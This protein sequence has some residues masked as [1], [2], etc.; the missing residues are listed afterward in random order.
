MNSSSYKEEK[1]CMV[2][3]KAFGTQRN[4]LQILE[5]NLWAFCSKSVP[6][7]ILVHT[8]QIFY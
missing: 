5:R 1:T 4:F 6:H 2:V 8:A 7:Y 3:G